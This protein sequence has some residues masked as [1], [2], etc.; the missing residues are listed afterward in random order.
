MLRGANG[1]D[2]GWL[3]VGLDV[4]VGGLAVIMC[5]ITPDVCLL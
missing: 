2:V 4:D 1:L 3:R 5:M